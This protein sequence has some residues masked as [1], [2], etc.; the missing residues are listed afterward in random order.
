MTNKSKLVN[1]DADFYKSLSD[2]ACLYCLTKKQ[3]YIIGQALQQVQWS[4]RWFGDASDLDFSAIAADLEARIASMDNCTSVADILRAI[5]QIQTNISVLQQTVQNGGTPP[6]SVNETVDTVL[7]DYAENPLANDIGGVTLPCG[8]VAEKD[9]IYGGVVSL[10]DYIVQQQGD[11]FEQFQL[12]QSRLPELFDRV[13]S[14]IPIIE[15]LPLDDIASTIEYWADEAE[16]LWEA[17]TT[18]D[19]I[20][21]FRCLLFCAIVANDCKFTPELLVSAMETKVPN[22]P[23]GFFQSSI[24][25]VLAYYVIGQPVGDEFWYGQLLFQIMVVLAGEQFLGASG[26]RP[27]EYRY[28]AGVN[29]PDNDWTIFCDECPDFYYYLDFNF[30]TDDYLG[31]VIEN[32]SYELEFFEGEQLAPATWDTR[33]YLKITYAPPQDMKIVGVGLHGWVYYDCGTTGLGVNFYND[34]VL[35]SGSGSSPIIGGNF[36]HTWETSV[37]VADKI[38]IVMDAKACSGAS[39]AAFARALGL[40]LWLASDSETKGKLWHEK[41]DTLAGGSGDTQWWKNWAQ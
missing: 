40:R 25:D 37:V 35:V 34:N 28:L 22:T 41:P 29:S 6:A 38:E 15:T 17:T 24:R 33:S 5:T 36:K 26:W 30:D 14:A 27:Y 21:D 18:E 12:V 19:R 32:G 13:V 39:P 31:W 7:N 11:F 1:W 20:Q 16:E 23:K 4:T 10:V 8:T 9:A 3:I 2:D